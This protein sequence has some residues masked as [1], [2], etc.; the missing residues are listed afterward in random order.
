MSDCESVDGFV[1]VCADEA[2]LGTQEP[3]QVIEQAGEDLEEEVKEDHG[4]QE[5]ANE[6]DADSE[7]LE[8]GAEEEEEEEEVTS[9]DDVYAA[10]D[11]GDETL[12]LCAQLSPFLELTAPSVPEKIAS[13]R[14]G[15]WF[16]KAF[17]SKVSMSVGQL[18]LL[19][20][21]NCVLSMFS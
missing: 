6:G 11:Q 1:H 10:S 14:F 5:E 17:G 21:G 18:L 15:D 9:E 8:S 19:L 3:D 12:Q 16:A 20:M 2:L 13:C 4:E 7:A